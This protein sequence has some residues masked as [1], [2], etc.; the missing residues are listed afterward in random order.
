MMTMILRRTCFV[1]TLGR[2][3]PHW[4]RREEAI[5]RRRR[6]PTLRTPG[7]RTGAMGITT[8]SDEPGAAGREV[9]SVRGEAR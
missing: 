8:G 9:N 7:P 4:S 3:P 2:G 1:A 5:G 6:S